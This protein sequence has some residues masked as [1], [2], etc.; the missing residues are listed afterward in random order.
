MNEDIDLESSY[1]ILQENETWREIWHDTLETEYVTCGEKVICSSPNHTHFRSLIQISRLL[2][3]VSN[4]ILKNEKFITTVTRE[5]NHY[6][7]SEMRF[8]R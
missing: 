1:E 4:N 8:S 3:E 5:L 2:V 6:Q 7:Y